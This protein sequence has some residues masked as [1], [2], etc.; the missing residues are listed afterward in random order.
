MS[1]MACAHCTLQLQSKPSFTKAIC[2]GWQEL[3]YNCKSRMFMKVSKDDELVLPAE[4]WLG[5]FLT[6]R[7]KI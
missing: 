1:A 2:I 6:N 3:S 4:E 7:K 5:I